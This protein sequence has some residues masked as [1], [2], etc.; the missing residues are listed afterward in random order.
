MSSSAKTIR[1][2]ARK[3]P[4]AAQWVNWWRDMI[5]DGNDGRDEPYPDDDG[6]WPS[7]EVAEQKALDEQALDVRVLG[8]LV[9]EWVGAFP[10]GETP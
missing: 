3:C 1:L 9:V 8:R 5:E 10:V 2:R 6:P 7:Y 4:P